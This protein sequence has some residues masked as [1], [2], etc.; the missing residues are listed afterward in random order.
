MQQALIHTQRDAAIA[1]GPHT[2]PAG[3]PCDR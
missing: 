2:T 3:L 1:A